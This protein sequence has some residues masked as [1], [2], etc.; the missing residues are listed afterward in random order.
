M[1]YKSTAI[2]TR[3][4]QWILWTL[5]TPFLFK[6]QS[7]SN[8]K[9]YISYNNNLLVVIFKI[10]YNILKKNKMLFPEHVLE[11]GGITSRRKAYKIQIPFFYIYF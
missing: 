5:F 11:G 4:V 1:Y 9:L 6:V 10:K 7:I 8:Y 3:P 2:S